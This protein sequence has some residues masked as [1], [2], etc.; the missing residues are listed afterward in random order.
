MLDLQVLDMLEENDA[1]GP[2]LPVVCANH[3]DDVSKITNAEDFDTFVRDGGCSRQC[4][5]RM[6]CGH[7][8]PRS[9]F[10]SR[11]GHALLGVRILFCGKLDKWN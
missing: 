10:T 8:C 9:A 11:P 2:A 5:A 1:V 6:P 7:S 3:P 4:I